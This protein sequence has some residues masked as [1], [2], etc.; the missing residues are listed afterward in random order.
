MV[1][2]EGQ[3]WVVPSLALLYFNIVTLTCMEAF[4]LS[5]CFYQLLFFHI[6]FFFLVLVF[7]LFFGFV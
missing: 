3:V 7:F 5:F 2:R 4:L 1:V 6:F